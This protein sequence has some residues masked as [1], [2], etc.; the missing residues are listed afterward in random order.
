MKKFVIAWAVASASLYLV[1]L[2]LGPDMEFEGIL[3]VVW[4]ALLLGLLNAIVAPVVKLLT[5]PVYLLTLGLFRFVVSAAFLLV[6]RSVVHGFWISGFWW[7]LLASVLISLA[8]TLI[9][10]VVKSED[11]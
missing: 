4:T 10:S 7:A 5:C 9:G 6:A 2:L 3:P 11:S 1:S 8:T